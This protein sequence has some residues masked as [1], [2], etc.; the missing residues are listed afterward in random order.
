MTDQ[1]LEILIG[2]LLRTGVISAAAVV[3]A[4][5]AWYVASNS[6]EPDYRAF[7]P[8]PLFAGRTGPE[9]TIEIGLLLLVATP[10][11][12]VI[13]SLIGFAA[14]RDRLYVA[15]TAIVLAILAYSLVAG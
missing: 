5:G 10:V 13:F 9:L 14:E 7:H 8:A 6:A 4:G 1:R 11:A 12:R 15:L 2:N 3:F